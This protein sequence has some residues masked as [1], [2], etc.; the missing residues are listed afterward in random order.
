VPGSPFYTIPRDCDS[1]TPADP[2]ACFPNSPACNTILAQLE[3]VAAG[4]KRNER[5]TAEI[6]MGIWGGDEIGPLAF[7]L[8]P[9]IR[10]Y[11]CVADN[12]KAPA[13]AAC[14]NLTCVRFAPVDKRP[15][16]L[17]DC[18]PGSLRGD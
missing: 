1:P 12:K 6:V 11:T 8:C 9:L 5:W 18:L 13:G 4:T 7:T 2:D 14:V 10:E 17:P 16:C 15:L 3:A